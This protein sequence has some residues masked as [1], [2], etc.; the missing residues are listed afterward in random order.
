MGF[1]APINPL[2]GPFFAFDDANPPIAVAGHGP[3]S[4]SPDETADDQVVRCLRFSFGLSNTGPGDFDIRD[5]GPAD[6]DG[7]V[8]LI[9]CVEQ[10]VG[11]PISR[12]SGTSAFHPTHLH[13]HFN[14][15]IMVELHRVTDPQAGTMVLAGDGRK[16]GYSPA[17]QSIADWFAFNQ[18]PPNTAGDAGTCREGAS[19]QFALSR[20]WGDVYRYQRAG[21]F[22]DFGTNLDGLYVIRLVI[23]PLNLVYEADETDNVGYTYVRVTLDSIE[24]LEHGRGQSPWDPNKQVLQVRRKAGV[25]W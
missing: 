19:T 20:G 13:N 14:D 21:N 2:N 16:L 11:T 4:C 24:V 23:D 9:Q 12:P 3:V 8:P 17:D 5:A 15:L 25:P 7:N 10:P 6:A 22:V 18:N 1:A